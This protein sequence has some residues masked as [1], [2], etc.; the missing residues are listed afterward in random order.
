M[1][2]KGE[3]FFLP[4]QRKWITDDSRLKIME[5]SRQIGI[6]M[7]TAYG[8]VR[9]HASGKLRFDSWVA[10]RDELQAKLFIGD[11]RNFANI[12]Q[13]FAKLHGLEIFDQKSCSFSIA[14][15]AGSSIHSLSSNPDAQA[16]KRGTRVLDEFALH[17]D[18]RQLF[19]ISLPGITWGGQLE[20]VSTHRGSNNFFNT[21]I[22]DIRENGNPKHFS[23]HRV[24]LEDALHQGFLRRLQRKLSA[25]DPRKTMTDG[26]YFDY[27]K[28]SCPDDD[29]FMQEYMCLP[30]DD[31]SAFLSYDLMDSCTFAELD[32]WMLSFDAMGRSKGDFY[33]GIDVGRDHDLTVMWLLEMCGDILLTRRVI[34]LKNEPFASQ[35]RTLCEF[36][37]LPNLRRICIDQTGIGRQFYERACECFG[38]YVVEGITFTNSVKEQLA[39]RVR[40]TFEDRSIKI[41]SD[42]H[43]RADLRAIKRETTFAGNVR[44]AADRGRNGHADR[45][46]ALA[47]AIHASA[48]FKNS[49]MQFFESLAIGRRSRN[50]TH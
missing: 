2:A 5:K 50:F 4:Y 26:E 21:L 20:I 32:N 17:Q 37:Q 23:H 39:Y 1:M 18:P 45:F 31:K 40:T 29:S 13:G 10:S 9:L 27:V 8:L 30:N 3:T 41:P 33:L 42:D 43:I 14:F 11:C 22:N 35:E 7:A 25:D 19:I 12:F 47:L 36:A 15:A 48:I 49:A 24:T 16:G 28:S 38:K 46:W 6:T 34:C 44:F